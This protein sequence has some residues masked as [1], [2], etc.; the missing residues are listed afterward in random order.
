MFGDIG[1]GFIVLLT[2]LYLVLFLKDP[3]SPLN[4]VKYL[5]LLMGIFSTFSGLIYNEFFAIPLI[6][7]PSCYVREGDDFIR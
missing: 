3:L 7:H 2:G 5:I 6:T 1:H 4:K